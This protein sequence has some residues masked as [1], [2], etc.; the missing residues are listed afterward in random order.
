MLHLAFFFLALLHLFALDL[1]CLAAFPLIR[2]FF[3]WFLQAPSKKIGLQNSGLRT[4]PPSHCGA[5]GCVWN[6]EWQ[7]GSPWITWEGGG[8]RVFSLSVDL[9]EAGRGKRSEPLTNQRGEPF[10]GLASA[11]VSAIGVLDRWRLI[12]VCP[13]DRQR[14]SGVLVPAP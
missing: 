2:F 13:P 9:R 5:Q 1:R 11:A 7:G 12:Y 6:L 14:G 10:L 4:V 8:G 3:L